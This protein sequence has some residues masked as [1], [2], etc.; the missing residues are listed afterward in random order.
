MSRDGCVAFPRGAMGLSAV[1][2]C[3]ISCSYSLFLMWYFIRYQK[4]LCFSKMMMV[5]GNERC[6]PIRLISTYRR[7]GH[8]SITIAYLFILNNSEAS[9]QRISTDACFKGKL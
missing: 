6:Q 7:T 3:G 4:E 5:E 9:N 2:D 1:C 8:A